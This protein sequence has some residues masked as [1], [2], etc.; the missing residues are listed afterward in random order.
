[1]VRDFPLTLRVTF[2]GATHFGLRCL[3]EVERLPECKV[4]GIV[5]APKQFRIS[6]RPQGVINVLHADFAEYGR[7]RGIPCLTMREKMN[8]P[9]LVDAIRGWNPNLLVV[10]GWYHM[11]P[12]VLREMAPAIGLHAS[13]L[14]DYCGGAPLVWAMINGETRTG[15]TLF[16]LGDGVDDGPVLAQAEE[17][18]L[19]EDTIATL[20][21]RIE[22]RGLELLRAELPRLARGEA[23]AVPQDPARRRVFPQRAPE[24]GVID[25]KWPARRIY[26]FVRA[27][28]RPYPGAFTRFRGERLT[29][30]RVEPRE[31][32]SLEAEA[33]MLIWQPGEES[34][35][36]TVTCGDRRRVALCEVGWQ[37][38][39]LSGAEFARQV[40]SGGGLAE[41]LG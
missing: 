40:A 9:G 2:I 5:T 35:E 4:V 13:L 12:K 17:P 41:R 8:E 24:D 3:Q 38:T 37:E 39:M 22:D 6:Y 27:Q 28:T 23:V 15:I 33:G 36:A 25:W 11:V 7:Q 10:V 14:P 29:L 20:Y 26:D 1:M 19:D 32:A 16:Q 18:I 31:A 34:P 30:W 21:A